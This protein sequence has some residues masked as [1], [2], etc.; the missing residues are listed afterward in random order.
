MWRISPSGPN[1]GL[2]SGAHQRTSKPPSGRRTSYRWTG[3]RSGAP[4]ASTRSSEAR[5]LRTPVAAGSSGLSGM[6]S[7]SGRPTMS[8]RRCI[9]AASQGSDASS[10][11]NSGDSTR[12]AVV[13]ASYSSRRRSRSACTVSIRAAAHITTQASAMAVA[14]QTLASRKSGEM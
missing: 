11:T 6:A 12:W 8:A 3:I 7:N 13:C 2:F 1:T 9:V 10:M 5:R 14:A 4:V